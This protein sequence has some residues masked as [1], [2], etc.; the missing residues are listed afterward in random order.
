MVDIVGL[1]QYGR[2]LTVAAQMAVEPPYNIPSSMEGSVRIIPNGFN[3]YEDHQAIISPIESR[4]NFPVAIDREDRKRQIIEDHF[5]VDFFLMLQRAER[6]MTATE[7]IEKMGEKAAVLGAMIGRF[8]SEAMDPMIDLA[9]AYELRAGR[10]PMPPDVLVDF[11]IERGQE[12]VN[13]DYMGP[14]AQAQKRLFRSQGILRSLEIAGPLMEAHPELG[15]MINWDALIV[16]LMEQ[17]GMPQRLINPAEIVEAIREQRQQ[18][19]EQQAKVEQ[20]AVAASSIK[21]LATADRQAEGAISDALSR[22]IS[23]GGTA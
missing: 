23:Q 12:P 10:A 11:M 19:M 14:L 1:N 9:F 20:G 15:D 17:N 22:V 21:D 13:I 4:K 18:Q 2:T 3:F 6:Q 16:D 5:H 7:V 8:I